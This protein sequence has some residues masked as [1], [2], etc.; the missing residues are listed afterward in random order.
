MARQWTCNH[1]HPADTSFGSRERML[2]AKRL[3]PDI[4]RPLVALAVTATSWRERD[5]I[6][7]VL[8]WAL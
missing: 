4:T 7:Q 1:L 5:D 2:I 6:E 8:I 3:I